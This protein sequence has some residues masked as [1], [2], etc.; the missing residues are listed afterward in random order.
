MPSR[1]ELLYF[2]NRLGAA[3]LREL[4]QRA[5]AARFEAI[6]S[7]EEDYDSFV[8]DQFVATATQRIKAGSS[9]ARYYKRHPLL[10]AEAA[11]AIDR[12]APGRF[13]I[14]LGTGPVKRADPSIKLQRWGSDPGQAVERLEEYVDIVRLALSG[15]EVNVEGEFYAV[16]R[17]RLNPVPL[18]QVPIYLSAG[19]PRLCRLAGRKADGVFFTFVGRE[20]TR[21]R[22]G[23]VHEEARAADRDPGS[24]QISGSVPVCVH[25]DRDLAREAFRRYLASMYLPLPHYQEL[26]AANG[27]AE[28]AGEIKERLGEGDADGAAS[29][30][31]DAAIDELGLA[32]EPSECKDGLARFFERGLTAAKLYPVPIGD[33]WPSA[34]AQTVDLFAAS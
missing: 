23:L 16:E 24:I 3:E 5:D 30:V 18:A 6:W 15:E 26:F 29:A 11:A 20:L 27:F 4:A 32:G 10:V 19:G 2:P 12:L 28:A 22:I 9:I 34:Y 8:Y 7:T 25:E 17:V 33:D 1:L 21:E 31:P 14:G 13:L